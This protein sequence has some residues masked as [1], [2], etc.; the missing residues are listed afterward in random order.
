[1][2]GGGG[3]CR[4]GW[5]LRLVYRGRVV[6][7]SLADVDTVQARA[8]ISTST[9]CTK[10]TSKKHKRGRVQKPWC[11]EVAPTMVRFRLTRLKALGGRELGEGVGALVG[12]LRVP[13]GL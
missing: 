1:M 7:M 11:P 3:G 12:A 5:V 2:G 9:K 6:D 4:T 13:C 8:R 10:C